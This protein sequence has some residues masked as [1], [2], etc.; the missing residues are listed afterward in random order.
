VLGVLPVV[1]GVIPPLTP[2]PPTPRMENS[3]WW[4]II[5]RK[6]CRPLTI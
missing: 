3:S 1:G 6:I 5:M 2:G 4:L